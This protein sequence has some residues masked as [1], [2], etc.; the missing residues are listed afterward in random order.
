MSRMRVE[1]HVLERA[2]VA[3]VLGLGDD[4][5]YADGLGRGRP[6]RDVRDEVGG[7]DDDLLVELGALVGA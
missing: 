6:P 1:V 3:V 5:V 4:V 7:L 2:P